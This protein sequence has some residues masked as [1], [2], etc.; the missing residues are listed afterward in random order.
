MTRRAALALTALAATRPANERMF[1]WI[2]QKTP[3]GQWRR[4]LI[5][6]VVCPEAAQDICR[7]WERHMSADFRVAERFYPIWATCPALYD[8]R[9]FEQELRDGGRLVS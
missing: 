2:E 1:Y 9:A 8:A 6:N 5:A 4:S 3:G 7:F